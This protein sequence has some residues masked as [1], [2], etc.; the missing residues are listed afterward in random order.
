VKDVAAGVDS[1]A[2]GDRMNMLISGSGG[3]IPDPASFIVEALRNGVPIGWLPEDVSRA[4]DRLDR[5]AAADRRTRAVVVAKL[6]EASEPLIMEGEDVQPE[7]FRS[8]VG[9]RIFTP[10]SYGV[11][12]AALCRS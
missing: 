10:A 1:Y 6:V 4:V 5:T 3:F 11:D 2:P 9:C 12:L 8:T 7:L